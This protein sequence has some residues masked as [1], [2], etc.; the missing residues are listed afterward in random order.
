MEDFAANDPP[1]ADLSRR[2]QLAAFYKFVALEE[3]DALREQLLAVAKAGAVQGTIL[4]AAEGLNGTVC[5]PEA[6]AKRSI[7]LPCT[8]VRSLVKLIVGIGFTITITVS[9]SE[10]FPIEPITV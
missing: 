5:G 10:Q 3:L 2:F 7:E 4:L 1:I 9:I 8:I 6:E